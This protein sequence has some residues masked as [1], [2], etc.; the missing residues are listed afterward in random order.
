MQDVPDIR[1]FQDSPFGGFLDF[2][3][4][5]N[6]MK[7]R[8]S[9]LENKLHGFKQPKKKEY[10][11]IQEAAEYL[12]MSVSS[13]RRVLKRGLLSKSI[14]LGKIQIPHESLENYRKVTCTF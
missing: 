2:L 5:W 8:I 9:H 7:E 10:Y 12:N 11:D 13:A 4:E 3:N 6:A 1:R 14:G